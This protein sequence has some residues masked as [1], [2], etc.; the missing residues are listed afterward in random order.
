MHLQHIALREMQPR[1]N[2][3]L[4]ASFDAG[5]PLRYRSRQFQPSF[6]SAF[7]PLQRCRLATNQLGAYDA[8]WLDDITRFDPFA[9]PKN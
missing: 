2:D 5:K 3:Q 9:L 8:D 6:R 7:I 4:V 1:E